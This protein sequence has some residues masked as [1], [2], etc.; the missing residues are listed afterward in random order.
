M[1]LFQRWR[2]QNVFKYLYTW[3][4]GTASLP[5][6]QTGTR[7]IVHAS[8]IFTK[9]W[10]T[11]IQIS[12]IHCLPWCWIRWHFTIHMTVFGFHRDHILPSGSLFRP[13]SPGYKKYQQGKNITSLHAAR[14]VSSKTLPSTFAWKWQCQDH[15]FSQNIHC[16]LPARSALMW[17]TWEWRIILHAAGTWN[18]RMVMWRKCHQILHQQWGE[19]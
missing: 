9:G 11:Q 17:L 10:F 19:H 5:C 15:I 13:N 16:S 2:Q 14:L 4:R 18:S 8:D 6:R 3:S 1:M 12:V 7:L